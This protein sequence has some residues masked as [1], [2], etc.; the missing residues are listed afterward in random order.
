MAELWDPIIKGA[1]AGLLLAVLIGGPVFVGLIKISIEKGF[2]VG[3]V[4]ALGV[5]A[6]DAS[7][8]I[9]SYLGISQ[10]KDSKL[11]MQILGAGGGAFMLGFGTK[12]ILEKKEKP[13]A[14]NDKLI[15]GP[16]YKNA[17]SGFLLNTLNPAALLF[18]IATVST[19]TVEFSNNTRLIITFF[20]VCLS[21]VFG[22][23][24]LKAFLAGKVKRLVTPTFMLWLHRITGLVFIA[25]GVE[26]VSAA[27]MNYFHF[28]PWG[29]GG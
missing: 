6:S 28:H 21:F 26:K 3:L 13:K 15:Q 19:V 7:F 22:T 29:I 23:D 2:L 27:A 12:L 4:F 9:I 5:I 24:V 8:L 11:V 17:L 16:W 14:I 20:I 25:V 18:W 10:L 1:A